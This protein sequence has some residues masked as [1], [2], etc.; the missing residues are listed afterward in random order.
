MASLGDGRKEDRETDKPSI[1][2][3]E[4]E[5]FEGIGAA[6]TDSFLLFWRIAVQALPP[7][8][9]S[10]VSGPA[11]WLRLFLNSRATAMASVAAQGLTTLLAALGAR[12]LGSEAYGTYSTLM[13]C[14]GWL[15]IVASYPVTA[16]VA[17]LVADSRQANQPFEDLC[18]AA[19][20]LVLG[21]CTLAAVLAPFL[22]PTILPLYRV[23]DDNNIALVASIWVVS[24]AFSNAVLSLL[25]SIGRLRLWSILFT[26]FALT[27]IAFVSTAAALHP[28]NLNE[29]V[30]AIALAGGANSLCG[31]GVSIYLLSPRAFA[32]PRFSV[33][34]RL[35]RA[36]LGPWLAS[37]SN[38]IA[39]LMVNT[40]IVLHIGQVELGYYH[41][42][43]TLG[44]LV[45]TVGVSVR[46][47]SLYQWAKMTAEGRLY[48]LRRDFRVG[49]WATTSAFAWVAAGAFI[50]AP[51]ILELFY[52]EEF[53]A[54]ASLLRIASIS[55]V[56]A[57]FGAWY[58]TCFS[59]MGHPGLV[60]VP[61]IFFGG[62]RLAIT[63]VLVAAVGAGIH[64]ALIAVVIAHAVWA[65]AYELFFR[66]LFR[67]ELARA[68]DGKLVSER[69]A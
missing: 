50:F 46:V 9:R 33:L 58:Y 64:G 16:L 13:T 24:S 26:V 69:P 27:P 36:G 52:G 7:V 48:S 8:P 25:Q 57:G 23:K 39:Y 18:T 11:I 66:R 5:R 63:W 47:P 21:I 56:V 6:L 19:L 14:A 65:A 44:G 31:A 34:R 60:I 51:Q 3:G 30:W 49:Q 28:L 29:Y 42:V 67:R 4:R 10:V 38:M 59:A 61:N 1:P 40:I 54:A 41:L 53:R 2:E 15:S 32:R 45:F 35:V 17:K 55:W 20:Y 43:S 37:T 22:I 12:L 68:D 62:L